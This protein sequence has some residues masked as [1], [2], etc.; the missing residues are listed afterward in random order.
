MG[1][2]VWRL[3]RNQQQRVPT[4]NN[5]NPH[6]VVVGRCSG[7]FTVSPAPDRKNGGAN[8]QF[9]TRQVKINGNRVEVSEVEACITSHPAVQ[10]CRV[11]AI[12]QAGNRSLGPRVELV[13]FVQV[14][15]DSSSEIL[16]V[17]HFALA[18]LP[19]YMVPLWPSG[20]HVVPSTGFHHLS[21]GKIDITPHVRDHVSGHAQLHG[22][23]EP[24]TIEQP[25][26]TLTILADAIQ[27]AFGFCV[28][29]AAEEI[30]HF[31]VFKAIQTHGVS[32]LDIALFSGYILRRFN[33]QVSREILQHHRTLPALAKVVTSPQRTTPKTSSLSN[34]SNEATIGAEVLAGQGMTR[35]R[36]TLNI[37]SPGTKIGALS[38]AWKSDL[39][40]CIDASPVGTRVPKNA[41]PAPGRS[42][43][44]KDDSDSRSA[45]IV[46]SHAGIIQCCDAQTG[47][48]VWSYCPATL[49]RVEASAT[50]SPCGSCAKV[51]ASRFAC[52][53]S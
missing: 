4:S 36:R 27:A 19:D 16:K 23:A 28:P 38:I 5:D 42:V 26:T 17:V 51:L 39:K 32:S 13:V 31:D 3:S 53:L 10:R 14:R 22:E 50:I 6:L 7:V 37:I 34:K 15:G 30:E 20:W 25:R 24:R 9:A 1:R 8:V 45:V 40:K 47:S 46:G 49:G 35:R 2:W 43:T 33:V 52:S 44:A 18:R 12:R 21:N 11:V 41:P 29:V 48:E